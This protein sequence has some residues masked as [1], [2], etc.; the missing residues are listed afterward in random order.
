M[1]NAVLHAGI[2]K[3]FFLSSGSL[4]P[5]LSVDETSNASIDK[6]IIRSIL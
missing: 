1:K 5:G 6:M 2:T 4:R 3:P